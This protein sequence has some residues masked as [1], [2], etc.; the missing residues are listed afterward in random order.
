MPRLV[1]NTS[2]LCELALTGRVFGA[3]DAL[4]LGIVSRVVRGSR[5]DVMFEALKLA[6]E[7]ARK[8]PVQVAVLGVKR[9]IAHMLDHPCVYQAN[10][11]CGAD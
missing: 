7:T 1:G 2:L 9:F 8:S 3:R 6:C 11:T 10:S 4:G 5:D